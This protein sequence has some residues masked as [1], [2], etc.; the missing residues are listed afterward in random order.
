[1][2]NKKLNLR[3][4]KREREEWLGEEGL[5]PAHISLAEGVYAFQSYQL[6]YH[7]IKKSN[8]LSNVFFFRQSS[9]LILFQGNVTS[10]ITNLY[11]FLSH[12]LEG[13]REG[14]Q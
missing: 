7:E 5:G 3:S 4:G 12:S 2:K 14:R 13:D 6:P 11:Y 10:L 1:M 8:A 9:M